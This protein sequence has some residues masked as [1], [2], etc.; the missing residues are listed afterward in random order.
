MSVNITAMGLSGSCGS[1]SG[2]SQVFRAK[3]KFFVPSVF[4]LEIGEHRF[5]TGLEYRHV[6]G[7]QQV[8]LKTFREFVSLIALRAQQFHRFLQNAG[9][10]GSVEPHGVAQGFRSARQE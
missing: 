10:I 4:P 3:A 1:S 6:P 9:D 5:P 7:V 2:L 8:V